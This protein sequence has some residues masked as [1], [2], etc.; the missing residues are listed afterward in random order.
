[1]T[2]KSNKDK[3]FDIMEEM[4]SS[5]KPGSNLLRYGID[6]P[7][8]K[9]RE[10]MPKFHPLQYKRFLRAKLEYIHDPS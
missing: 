8:D 10:C 9:L 6:M 7:C 2:R 4:L 5:G 1:M 3:L